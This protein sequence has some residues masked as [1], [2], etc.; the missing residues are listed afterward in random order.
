MVPAPVFGL[1]TLPAFQQ[2]N[3]QNVISCDELLRNTSFAKW[4]ILISFRDGEVAY[5]LQYSI[6][7]SRDTPLPG[8]HFEQVTFQRLGSCLHGAR[9]E[10]HRKE[11]TQSRGDEGAKPRGD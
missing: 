4:F 6:C 5:S 7:V 1:L 3:V 9:T 10:H 11:V 2:E 8:A